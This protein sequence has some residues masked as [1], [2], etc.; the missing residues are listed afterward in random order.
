MTIYTTLL[1]I[2]YIVIYYDIYVIYVLFRNN[3]RIIYNSNHFAST[4]GA[5]Y[6]SRLLSKAIAQ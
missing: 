5:T 4:H 6:L 1:S 2:Y 3:R